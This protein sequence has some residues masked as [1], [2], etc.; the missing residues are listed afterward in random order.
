[1]DT[2]LLRVLQVIHDLGEQLTHNQK[3]TAA[4]QTQANALKVSASAL[5]TLS[6]YLSSHKLQAASLDLL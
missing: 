6:I 4:L 3:I 1:M 5:S 2:D